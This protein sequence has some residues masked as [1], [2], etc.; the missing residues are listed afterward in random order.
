VT[1]SSVGVAEGARVGM[2]MSG[3]MFGSVMRLI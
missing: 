3:L 1:M 2:A